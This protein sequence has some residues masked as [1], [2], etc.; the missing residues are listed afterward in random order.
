MRRA[1]GVP[2]QDVMDLLGHTPVSTTV[3]VS[4][5]PLEET[6]HKTAD[7]M[8]S[9]L[10]VLPGEK[11]PIG[12]TSAVDWDANGRTFARSTCC[13]RRFRSEHPRDYRSRSEGHDPPTA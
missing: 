11:T 9:I 13:I 1:Q 3:D 10:T 7:A 5:T 8:R 4:R 6:N 2:I 12:I